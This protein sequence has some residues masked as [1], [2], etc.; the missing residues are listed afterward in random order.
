MTVLLINPSLRDFEPNKEYTPPLSILYLA[1]ILQHYGI[2]VT[3]LDL[4]AHKPWESDLG[5]ERFSEEK[6][7]ERVAKDQPSLIGFTCIFSGQFPSIRHCSKQIRSEYKE[8]PIVIGGTHPTLY[9]KEIITNC[10]AID[11]VVI[12]EGEEQ[13][14][15]LSRAIYAK[16]LNSLS[17][18]EGIAYRHNG[19]VVV[20]PKRHFIENLDELPLPA[21]NLIKLEDYYHPVSHWHNPKKLSFNMTVPV[22]SSRSCPNRCNFCMN[23]LAMGSKLRTRSPQ[24][25]V[26][27]IQLLH[28]RYGQNHF[29]FMD[30]NITLNK[31]HIISMCNEIVR[32][33]L[34]IQY[35]TP[36][37]V[38]LASLNHEVIEAMVK[39]GWVRGA[40]AIES[41]SDFIRN[42]VMAKHLSREK[43]FEVVR[44]CKRYKNLYLKGAFMMGMPEE[45]PET[46]M[47]TCN[48]ILELGLD[49]VFVTNLMPYPG[50]SVFKQAYRDGLITDE[51]DSK[52]LWKTA[53]FHYHTNKKFYI[54]PYKMTIAEL[55]VF[56]RKF[57]EL[58]DDINRARE[59]KQCANG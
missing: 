58:I 14:V 16:D 49:E 6:I 10:P 31:K 1:G 20:H 44:I 59:M 43:I 39:A 51:I 25:V 3:I 48:M 24:K 23:Y 36:N 29:S 13:I 35:E 55:E 41:G 30:D 15:A 46:L 9:A 27:E 53:G 42:K 12:G 57:D 45:T 28:D 11:Y 37:G 4:S 8:I 7:M 52:N 38:F 17:D 54:K 2:E 5:W 19:Q 22:I 18:L 40:L 21:Y 33:H 34:D 47:D 26:D 32:R 56:R 50:T